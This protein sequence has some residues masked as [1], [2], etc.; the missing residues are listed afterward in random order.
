MKKERDMREDLDEDLLLVMREIEHGLNSIDQ[1]TPIQT[2][3]IEWFENLIVEEKKNMKKKL[4][5]DASLFAI[6][7]LIIL[8]GIL[9][10]LYRVPIVFFAIQGI[11][12]MFILA[13]VSIQFV[14]QVKET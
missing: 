2:P 11:A 9:F 7:A 14:K 8:T 3:N 10:A 5:F 12:V 1:G 13:F 4:I 6:L